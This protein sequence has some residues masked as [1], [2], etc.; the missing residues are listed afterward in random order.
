MWKRVVADGPSQYEAWDDA[1]VSWANAF[2][3]V[4]L[5][6]FTPYMCTSIT[7]KQTSLKT[8]ERHCIL[9]STLS[10]H[11]CSHAWWCPGV[12]GSLGRGTHD[13]NPAASR[14]FPMTLGGTRGATYARIS[15]VNADLA[16]TATH[17]M[18]RHWLA[19]VLSDCS[20]S[21]LRVWECFTDHCW[22]QRHTTDTLC[23]TCSNPSMCMFIRL[24]AGLQ[25][26]SSKLEHVGLLVGGQTLFTSQKQKSYCL[27]KKNSGRKDRPHVRHL[28]TDDRDVWTLQPLSMHIFYSGVNKHSSEDIYRVEGK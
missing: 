27:Q 17:T 19:S 24:P 11:Q 18:R 2:R 9:Q 12:S 5:T 4:I 20:E 16:A 8:T 1:C 14:R 7:R 22:K 28:I 6:T 26:N 13:L 21:G 10:R 23:P 3:K 25:C 15:S